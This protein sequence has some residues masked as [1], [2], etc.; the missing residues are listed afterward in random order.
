MENKQYI[1]Q[2]GKEFTLEMKRQSQKERIVAMA[3]VAILLALITILSVV[4]DGFFSLKNMQTILSQMAI[5]LVMSMGLTFVIL[6]GSID[7]SGE[8]LGGF[9]GSI[10][11]LMVLNSKN[12]MDIGAAGMI[13]AVAS[14]LAVGIASG[15]IHVKGR[16]PS[17]M[18]TYAISSIMAGIAVLSYQG[19]PAMIQYEVFT[20]LAQGTFLGIP[21]LTFIALL[22]FAVAFI[23]QE[24][25]R[26]GTYVMA[27]G[28][29][30]SVARN[31]GININKT[32]IMVFT[33]MG[34]CIGIAGLLGAIRIGRGEV[35][36][37]TG[38]VFPAV[39]AVV[40]GGTALTGGKGGV[41][42]SLIGTIIVT[43]INNGLIL[44]GVNTYIQSATQGIII[45][46]AVALSVARG[47]KIIVK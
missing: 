43:V 3:P 21:Y 24:Y 44:L 40:V 36:I 34:L 30:E 27:I 42:N 1:S 15:I 47:K 12:T 35:A 8:G 2:I 22:V 11:A 45:I 9:V 26:F 16:M 6:L 7:L 20:I 37:G 25:T 32:K 19:Q 17:F 46:A 31:T 10:V 29:N 18:V 38:T 14:G 28:D 5:P 23:L 41:V 4:A 39:T 33:W 13:I